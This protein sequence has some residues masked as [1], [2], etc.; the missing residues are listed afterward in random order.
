MDFWNTFGPLEGA[1]EGQFQPL[2]RM[3][4]PV[5]SRDG[6]VASRYCRLNANVQGWLTSEIA[7]VIRVAD[8]VAENG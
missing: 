2:L 4:P 3:P 1:A 6:I 7:P 5:A 8:T